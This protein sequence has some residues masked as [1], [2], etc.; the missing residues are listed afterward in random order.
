MRTLAAL[1]LLSLGLAGCATASIEEAY[2]QP[3]PF[4]WTYFHGSPGD[5]VSAIGE[6]FQ[7]SGTR[8]E[9]VQNEADG[10]VMTLSTRFGSADFSQI[11]VQATDV[12]DYSARAQIYPQGDPLP[13]WLETEVSGRM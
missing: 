1:V 13:R 12:E 2:G 8:I 11:R 6:A 3:D 9:S 4:E 10:V 5:V 7:Q